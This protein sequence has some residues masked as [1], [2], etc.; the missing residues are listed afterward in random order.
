MCDEK[1][2]STV[3]AG[4]GHYV[5]EKIVTSE[6]ISEKLQ[7]KKRF[8]V[9]ANIIEMFTGVRERR[10]AADHETPSSLAANAAKVAI[11][12]AGISPEDIE[13]L[14]YGSATQDFIEPATSCV[15]Q[16]MIGAKNA[17]V[18]DVKN[19]CNSFINGVDIADSFIRAGKIK[20]ALVV[21]GEITTRFINWDIKTREELEEKFASLTIG[22]AG[23]A[24]VL[25]ASEDTSK[26]IQSSHFISRGDKWELAVVW[27]GGSIY[28]RDPDKM[29]FSAHSRELLGLALDVVPE[30]TR[31]ALKKVGW[32]IHEVDFFLLHQVSRVIFEQLSIIFNVPITKTLVSLEHYGNTAAASIPLSL[33]LALE[34]GQVKRGDKIMLGGGASGFCAGMIS[35]IY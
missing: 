16:S 5:P 13:L 17:S 1:K 10:F 29:Y 28:P 9:P 26:G 22:D 19:A 15:I 21:A 24:F 7:L 34:K 4:V 31:Q 18:F 35:L 27:G 33:S 23:G 25:T 8:K 30:T 6:E 11:K 32:D 2:Y 20:T 14:I 3:I 12:N